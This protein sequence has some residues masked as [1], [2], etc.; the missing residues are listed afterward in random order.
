FVQTVRQLFLK[1]GQQFLLVIDRDV[2]H[3][4]PRLTPTLLG[5]REIRRHVHDGHGDL[6]DT[7]EPQRAPLN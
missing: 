1:L 7:S 5:R 6:K 4:S 3:Q 2:L